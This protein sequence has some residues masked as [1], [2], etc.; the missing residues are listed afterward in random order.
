[1]SCVAVGGSATRGNGPG[2]TSCT[3]DV[4]PTSQAHPF[5]DGISTCA[6]RTK[7]PQHSP[8][9]PVLLDQN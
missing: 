4:C 7:V 3:R 9:E 2:G 6:V 8:A 5:A 1:M